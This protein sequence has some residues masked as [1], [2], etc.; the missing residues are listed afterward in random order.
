MQA[1]LAG[2]FKRIQDNGFAL[3]AHCGTMKDISTI[4][5]ANLRQ[6]KAAFTNRVGPEKLVEMVDVALKGPLMPQAQS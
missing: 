4:V 5:A 6:S 3:P 1:K 2:V